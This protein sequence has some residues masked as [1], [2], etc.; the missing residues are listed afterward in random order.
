MLLI[1]KVSETP[2]TRTSEIDVF[3]PQNEFFYSA[4]SSELLGMQKEIFDVDDIQP[5]PAQKLPLL[6]LHNSQLR[7]RSLAPAAPPPRLRYRGMLP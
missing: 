4:F 6:C 1:F 7:R 2:T 3:L 5:M